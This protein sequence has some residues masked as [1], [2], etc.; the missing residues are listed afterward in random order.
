M[1]NE[2]IQ[3]SKGVLSSFPRRVVIEFL[4]LLACFFIFFSVYGLIVFYNSNSFSGFYGLV[5]LALICSWISIWSIDFYIEKYCGKYFTSLVYPVPLILYAGASTIINHRAGEQ[6]ATI[7]GGVTSMM[8]TI[9]LL[10]NW[11]KKLPRS[12]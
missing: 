7:M 12:R 2:Q 10:S 8:L 5:F 1:G 6:D 11:R 9:K 4:H 3:N